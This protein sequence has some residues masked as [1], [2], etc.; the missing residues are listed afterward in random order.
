MT[1]LFDQPT[2]IRPGEEVDTARLEEY[3]H[4]HLVD[5]KGPLEVRQY[6][7][8]HSNLTYALNLGGREL[9]LRRPPF[10]STVKSAHDMGRE[11]RVLSRLHAVYSPAPEVLLYCEDSSVLGAPF[12]VM[13][14]IHGIILRRRLPPGLNLSAETARQ[15]SEAFLENLV[16]LHHVDY[17][18]AGL[19][20]LGRPNGYLERQVRGWTERYY[21]SKTN[22]YAEVA[23]LSAWM[24]QNM[25]ST[26]AVSL[27]HND[28]KYDNVI[29]D[30]NEV[31][32]II[33]VLDWESVLSATHS[34]TLAP[35]LRIGSML[36]ILRSCSRTATDRLL[37]LGA[38]DDRRSWNTT[39]ARPDATSRRLAS[40]S[41]LPV[42]SWPLFCSKS[43]S[44]I[45]RASPEMS[46]S[47]RCP[48]QFML[49]SGA[50]SIARRQ[51][52]CSLYLA[53]I[54]GDAISTLCIR[55]RL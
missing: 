27:I 50:R 48:G 53:T 11:V 7:S 45:T 6:P 26:S 10:G 9:V 32:R 16:S 37:C 39:L 34:P 35:R 21:G 2:A 43:I 36:A 4:S 18:A 41:R 29:L 51:G 28:Y 54:V 25:P 13:K 23:K 46:G 12:Y 22:D 38:L 52:V 5:E 55:A 49:C 1:S 42:L 31:T 40:I 47:C 8:G 17:A 33:G 20:D 3:R 30:V 19:A 24:E 44:V 15:L 14:P